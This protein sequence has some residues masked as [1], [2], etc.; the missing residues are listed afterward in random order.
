[1]MCI[2]SM[3]IDLIKYESEYYRISRILF[4]GK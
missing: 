3:T 2:N 4:E 1:M